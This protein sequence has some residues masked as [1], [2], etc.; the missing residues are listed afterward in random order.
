MSTT[1]ANEFRARW[2]PQL[3][4][5]IESWENDAVL[6]EL[7]QKLDAH[8][9]ETSFLDATAEAIVAQRLLDHGARLSAEVR[10]PSGRAAD[11][12]VQLDGYEFY[13]H[14]KRADTQPRPTA[15]LTISSRLR[16]LE[17]LARPYMVSIRWNPRLSDEQMQTFVERA[18]AF[19]LQARVGDELVVRDDD[20]RE[21]GGVLVVAPWSGQ[22]V[23][24]TIGLPGGF[25]DE[26][27]RLRRLL[28]RAY[29]QFMP[30]AMN[31]ILVAT[32][33]DH[34][35]N[36]FETAL[37]GAHIERWDEHPPQGR[38]IAHGRAE[39]GF[40]T[41]NAYAESS[42]AAWFRFDPDQPAYRGR[43]WLRAPDDASMPEVASM[44]RVLHTVDAPLAGG[45]QLPMT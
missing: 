26:T 27:Q 5:S 9:D 22:H 44:A 29:K 20:Q 40:W 42:I 35:V 34:D 4:A 3:R 13:L 11:F 1:G 15:K 43:M 6:G 45:L 10:T 31:V 18:T 16:S 32:S 14:V 33:S 21:L 36:P 39:D 12:H 8:S 17:R 28:R 7:Y 23:L 19:I 37:L 30:R 38:R 24:L 2:N 25:V 41:Q